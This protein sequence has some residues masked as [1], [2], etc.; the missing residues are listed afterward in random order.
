M[1]GHFRNL[2]R[3]AGLVFLALACAGLAA[4]DPLFEV[5]NFAD[6]PSS[7]TYISGFSGNVATT[8]VWPAEMGWQGRQIDIA[9]ALPATLPPG[10]LQY[11]F[12]INVNAT[13]DQQVDLVIRAGPTLTSLSIVHSETISSPRV[14]HAVIPVGLFAAGQT[15]YIRLF[16]NGVQ[17]GVGAPSGCQ[18]NRWTLLAE[19][20][21][22]PNL[23]AA[24]QD[25]LE[26]L[27]D[28]V[29]AAVR[30]N[31][32]VRDSL[33][34]SPFNAPFHP[35][36]PDAAGFALLALCA[37]DRLGLEPG[38]E[39]LVEKILSA[40]SGHTPG[41][42]PARNVYGHWW[43]W[44]DI[45]TGGQAAGWGDAYTT[46]G[47]ALL[48]SGAQFAK[49]HFRDNPT[50]VA[51]ADEIYST[52][53]FDRMINPAL[54]G[55]VSV[56]TYYNGNGTGSLVPWNEYM[57]IVSLALDQPGATRAPVIQ[58]KW[59]NPANCPKVSYAGI[60]TLTDSAAFAPAFWVHQAYYFNADFASN[61]AF[62][63]YFEN[64]RTADALYCTTAL[65]QLYRYGLTAGVSPAGYTADRIFAHTNVFSPEAVAA[66][67]DLDTFLLFYHFQPPDSDPRFRYGLTRVS[68][69]DPTWVPYDAGLV[70]HLFMMFGLVESIEPPFFKQRQ[71]FQTDNDDD[72]IADAYDNCPDAWNRRQEDG[73]GDG[74]G[75]ACACGPIWADADGDGD[76]DLQDIAALQVC[77]AAPRETPEACLCFDRDADHVIRAADLA[78]MTNC[79]D[80]SGPDVPAS[81]CT[82]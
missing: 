34:L 70:D 19:S 12:E 26:R 9:F 77:A 15:N 58:H 52:C 20:I 3:H 22:L 42:T 8:P 18:W 63:T 35:A 38:A 57:L 65:N 46:I 30:P 39:T 10:T 33:T 21:A 79:L 60:P 13:F 28:Y 67:G 62:M 59:L 54:D 1:N 32:L 43:H 31:G 80:A 16:G 2:C 78:V 27:T 49:N 44:L 53:N 71:A 68:A 56:A 41:V 36:T 45:N 72:G 4:A 76:V 74:A 51:R 29:V 82:P 81:G 14:V 7:V 55:R 48:A 69:D 25:Q 5:T 73:D 24:R 75:D 17:V 40:Y 37:A 6:P 47:S 64:Q 23:D 50:I 66:W 61:P 11:A